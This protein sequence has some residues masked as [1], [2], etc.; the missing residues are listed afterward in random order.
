MD[1]VNNAMP[2]FF[3]SMSGA[4]MSMFRGLLAYAEPM[5]YEQI[6]ARIDSTQVVLVSGEQDN[7]FTPGGGGAPQTWAGIRESGTVAK[8]ASTRSRSRSRP[9]ST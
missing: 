9:R 3:H 6:F 2:A 1:I 8:G 7:V 5:T 4:T